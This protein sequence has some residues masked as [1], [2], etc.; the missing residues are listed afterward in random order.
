MENP[1]NII[2]AVAESLI[3][4]AP[5]NSD[6]QEVTVDALW[7]RGRAAR[8]CDAVTL[9]R[10]QMERHASLL[11]ACRGLLTYCVKPGGMP[12]KGKGRTDEQQRAFDAARI[13]IATP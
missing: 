7:L 2:D 4:D 3:I 8:L 9:I 6:D 5:L 11:A 12:D 1:I 10:G 13:A